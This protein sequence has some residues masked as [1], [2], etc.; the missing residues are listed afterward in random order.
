MTSRTTDGVRPAIPAELATMLTRLR[1]RIRTY[2]VI[3]GTAMLL[4]LL[5]LVF[6]LSLGLDWAWFRVSRLELP[7]WFRVVIDVGALSLA[8]AAAMSWIGLRWW[9]RFRARGLALVLERRFPELDDRLI[10]AVEMTDTLEAAETPLERLMLERTLRDVVEVSRQLDVTDVFQKR[11]LRRSVVLAVALVV[12]I[13]GLAVADS[14]VLSRWADGYLALKEEYWPREYGLFVTVDRGPGRQPAGFDRQNVYRHPRGEDLVLAIEVRPDPSRKQVEPLQSVEIDYRQSEGT[15][16]VVCAQTGP[17]QFRHSRAGLLENMTFRVRGGDYVNRRPF[18][19]E[20]VDP[21]EVEQVVLDCRYAE[22]TRMN[23]PESPGQRTR[24][25]VQGTQIDLPMETD[26][27]LQARTNKPYVGMQVE[28]DQYRLSV[29]LADDGSVQAWLEAESSEGERVRRRPID[30]AALG[31]TQELALPARVFRLPLVIST[32]AV[33]ELPKI[34]SAADG[35]SSPF[36]G[37]IPVPANVQLRFAIHDTDDIIS[38]DP[39]LLTINGVVDEPPVIETNLRGIGTE[40]TRIARIPVA[41]LIRD[42]YGVAE[43]H[44]EFQV[45]DAGQRADD[46][47]ATWQKRPLTFSPQ[48]GPREFSLATAAEDV[49]RDAALKTPENQKAA[50]F[51]L[52]QLNPEPTV[53][54]KLVLSIVATDAD[55]RNGPHST[56]S[57]PH[58]IFSIVSNEDLQFTLMQ[59]ELNLR[60]RFE[61]VISEVERT[62]QDLVSHRQQ[63]EERK[64]QADYQAADVGETAKQ[65]DVAVTNC[66]ERSI[67]EI[68]KSHNET[69]AIAQQFIEIREE[70][71]NNGVHTPQALERIDSGIL[72][73]LQRINSEDYTGVETAL[74][75]FARA[76]RA[77]TDPSAEM[78]EAL[79]GLRS[80]LARMK[81]VLKEM[82]RLETFQEALKLLRQIIGDEEKLLEKTKEERKRDLIKKLNGLPPGDGD[83]GSR[84]NPDKKSDKKSDKKKT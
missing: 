8:A 26:V 42:D 63:V 14:A 54:Q 69:S 45:I 65:I 84:R 44:F 9:R 16:R 79:D 71:I 2:V 46:L 62:Q 35:S 56:R 7:V 3:E 39:A 43:A 6:W 19:I 41:G 60:R 23:P 4:V 72:S 64:V 24:V 55:D 68:S 50:W 36:P 20:V 81:L 70:L 59:K 74:R 27:L 75:A 66:A 40:V 5:A 53:G 57:S 38:R 21:P 29:S 22:Y 30:P 77:S 13:G 15:G 34:F 28:F 80:L 51:D 12:S 52:R 10:T 1:Q 25:A 37:P 33:E 61:Q 31:L 32:A 58:Y 48:D 78:D 76:N 11:P 47:A 17:H 73:P 82:Q 83:D 49:P 67:N 18:R